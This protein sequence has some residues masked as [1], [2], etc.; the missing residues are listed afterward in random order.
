VDDRNTN[1]ASHSLIDTCTNF[2][3]FATRC[4]IACTYSRSTDTHVC[5][6]DHSPTDFSSND[7]A[8]TDYNDA[9]DVIA[10]YV[11]V[12]VYIAF[13]IQPQSAL[14]FVSEKALALH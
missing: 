8:V 2:N 6:A 14:H 10:R 1:A 5:T 13:A 7:D 3:E 11:A 9:S 4:S 12:A